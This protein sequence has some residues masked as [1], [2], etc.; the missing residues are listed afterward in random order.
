MLLAGVDGEWSV[1]GVFNWSDSPR[2]VAVR[3][4][5]MGLIRPRPRHVKDSSGKIVET[6]FDQHATVSRPRHVYDFWNRQYH[7]LDGTQFLLP[8]IP[9]HG[10]HVLGI[11]L[12]QPGP[13]LVATS[14]HLSQGGEIAAWSVEPGR[15]AFTIALGHRAEGEVLLC[16]ERPIRAARAEGKAVEIV[17]VGLGVSA[18]RFAVA[19]AA[20]VEAL[21]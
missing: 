12:V 4:E 19:K 1:V 17:Q 7:R 13:H 15:L 9:A 21:L 16:T 5:D 18:L 8:G 3:L 2:D 11:R 20:R 6:V 10:C 14:F